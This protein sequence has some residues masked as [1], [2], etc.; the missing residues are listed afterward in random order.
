MSNVLSVAGR[1]TASMGVSQGGSD[2]F[3]TLPV[4]RMWLDSFASNSI[5]HTL[6]AGLPI[7]KSPS[8]GK[9]SLVLLIQYWLL[10]YSVFT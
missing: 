2:G 5:Q 8:C 1:K 4:F 3:L 10:V 9:H 6:I 7:I